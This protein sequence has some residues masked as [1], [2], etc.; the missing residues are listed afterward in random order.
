[1]N[2]KRILTT[3]AAIIV[4]SVSAFAQETMA[5]DLSG[6]ANEWKYD[7]LKRVSKNGNRSLH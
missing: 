4:A 7:S 5:K 3:L 6:W 2:M 1:M